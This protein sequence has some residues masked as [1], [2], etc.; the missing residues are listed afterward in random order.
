MTAWK[1]W[2]KKLGKISNKH[3]GIT[4]KYEAGVSTGLEV[5]PK[6][7]NICD[8][9]NV[10]RKRRTVA[11]LAPHRGFLNMGDSKSFSREL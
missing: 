5:F 6:V 4:R 7:T 1:I 10:M 9:I 2:V 8:D 11:A 3:R